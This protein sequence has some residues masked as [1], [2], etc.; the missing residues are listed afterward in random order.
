MAASLKS[1]PAELVKRIVDMVH[2]QDAAVRELDFDQGRFSEPDEEDEDEDDEDDRRTDVPRGRWNP[3]HGRGIGA[4]VQVS[5]RIRQLALPHLYERLTAKQISSDFFGFEVLGEPAQ[6]HVRHVEF[7]FYGSNPTFA[8]ACALRKL[9]SLASISVGHTHLRFAYQ[10]DSDVASVDTALRFSDGFKRALRR[11][12]S[13]ETHSS[14]RT[15]SVSVLNGVDASRLRKLTLPTA[16]TVFATADEQALQAVHR[17]VALD[18]LEL[19]GIWEDGADSMEEHLRVPTVRKLVLR[20]AVSYERCL[21]LAHFVAPSLSTLIIEPAFGTLPTD[22]SQSHPT[23]LL[24]TLRTLVIRRAADY[25]A[26]FHEL[27]PI[28]LEHFYIEFADHVEDFPLDEEC[29]SSSD[30]P[31]SVRAITVA[32]SSRIELH[33]SP[34]LR[35]R[36][37]AL[38][39]RL[40]VRRAPASEEVLARPVIHASALAIPV[41][42]NVVA[43]AVDETLRWAQRRARWLVEVGDGV[44]LHELAQATVRLRERHLLDLA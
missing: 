28:A 11:V 20:A 33:P 12:T 25:I 4:L 6:E 27:R 35:A 29:L 26:A 32:F 21:R 14:D 16:G 30:T 40:I 19:G 10:V 24:P 42:S 1:L 34:A 22:A 7:P 2:A 17:L 36:C 18:E 8:L 31:S 9:P 38:A 37:D 39:V 13:L 5:R 44:G 23:P 3:W 43:R 41:A 15:L